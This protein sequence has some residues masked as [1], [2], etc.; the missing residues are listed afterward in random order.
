MSDLI[1][2]DQ[3]NNPVI[4]TDIA[5][6]LGQIRQ[7][8]K[9]IGDRLGRLE[10]GQAK[11]EGKIEAIDEKLS[12]QI[13]TLDE[14]VSGK[15]EATNTKAEQLEKRISNQEFFNRIIGG[16]LV[17]SILGGIDGFFWMAIKLR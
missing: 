15:I 16:S 7:E 1:G 13:R 4:Q 14:K 3:M 9:T 6:V 5:E 11:I 10:V 12:G 2:V 17:V 8:L